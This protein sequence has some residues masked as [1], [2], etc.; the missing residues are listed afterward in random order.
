[1]PGTAHRSRSPR[2]SISFTI[3]A[4]LPVVLLSASS[5]SPRLML[6][7]GGGRRHGGRGALHTRRTRA[8]THHACTAATPHP[9]MRTCR[10]GHLCVSL[11]RVVSSCVS[12][13]GQRSAARRSLPLAAAAPSQP[14]P[15]QAAQETRLKGTD[16]H[17]TLRTTH[18]RQASDQHQH[19]HHHREGRRRKE[20]RKLLSLSPRTSPCDCRPVRLGLPE[21]QHPE[22]LGQL[23]TGM[24]APTILWPWAVHVQLSCCGVCSVYSLAWLVRTAHRSVP[25]CAAPG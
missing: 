2:S 24:L 8:T 11:A 6:T 21:K 22:G 15:P 18:A 14:P 20:A 17:A 9:R 10:C 12:P 7:G 3:A 13:C 19:Q 23:W 5:V 1:M 25:A 4:A 16:V